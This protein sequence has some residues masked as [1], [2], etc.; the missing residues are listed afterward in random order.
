MTLKDKAIKT[1]L[2]GNW[3]EAINFN[4][5]LL[6]ESPDDAEALNRL[7]LAYMVLGEMNKAKITYQKV[8]RLDPLNPIA[9]KNLKCLKEK[10]GKLKNTKTTLSIQ[11]SNNFLEETGKTKVIELINIAPAK[12]IQVLRTGQRVNLCIKR[13]KIFILGE[14]DQYIGVLPDDIGKRLIRFIKSGNRY[15]ACIKSADAHKVAIFIKETKRVSKFKDHPSFAIIADIGLCLDKKLRS[16][17]GEK[18]EASGDE[19]DHED[20]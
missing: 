19:E 10:I 13:L 15:D 1:A 6:K 7:A 5:A 9:I 14:D 3:K 18:H 17:D 11:L 16:L 4:K 20:S 12:T 8:F 2:E